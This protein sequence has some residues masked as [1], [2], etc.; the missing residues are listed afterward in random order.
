MEI[1]YKI[2][3]NEVKRLKDFYDK[4]LE[5]PFVVRRYEKNV[6]KKNGQIAKPQIW[7]TM[8]SCLLS[9][10]QR[11]GPES[12]VT[13]FIAAKAFPLKYTDCLNQKDCSK[14]IKDVISNFKGLRRANTIG[15]E[16][17]HNLKWLEKEGWA[18][19]LP[20]FEDLDQ[21]NSPEK[22]RVIANLVAK[23]LKGFGPKQSRNLLQSLGLTKYEIPIDSRIVKWLNNFGF[24]LK[25]NA[26]ALSD[27]AYYEFV[28]DVFQVLCDKANIYPCLMD[29]AIFTSFD[30]GKWKTDQV[31]L[32][33]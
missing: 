28:S 17:D 16:S 31:V 6:L 24:P 9:T 30:K 13:K 15:K 12:F 22:E 3:S 4:W 29:A 2:S 14:Y 8:I 11:S 21:N 7:E 23:H 25:L 26:T 20:K 33:G 18:I 32:V 19:L 1:I 5:D 27:K 10:Q